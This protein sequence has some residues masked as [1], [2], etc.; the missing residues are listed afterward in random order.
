VFMYP[1][2]Q[3]SAC[4]SD[5]VLVSAWDSVY[6]L[7]SVHGGYWVFC[8]R[9]LLSQCVA[10]FMCRK[11]PSGLSSLAVSSEAFLTYG[12]VALVVVCVEFVYLNRP[13][14]TT[15]HLHCGKRK[16]ITS[17]KS[18]PKTDIPATL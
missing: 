2:C 16:R 4:L 1:G 15:A 18:L 5:V 3:G 12:I 6:Y 13:L 7:G 17:I 9:Q 11:I 14:H 8:S 10:V